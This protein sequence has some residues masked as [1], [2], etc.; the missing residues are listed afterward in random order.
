M[1]TAHAPCPT[2]ELYVPG[3]QDVHTDEEEALIAVAYVP[4]RNILTPAKKSSST[5]ASQNSIETIIASTSTNF[6]L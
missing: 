3:G 2:A 5:T 6:Y 1:Q 4:A